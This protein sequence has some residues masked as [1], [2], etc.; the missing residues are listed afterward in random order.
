V[1]AFCIHASLPA[2]QRAIGPTLSSS[3][4]EFALSFPMGDKEVTRRCHVADRKIRVLDGSVLHCG[5]S[6]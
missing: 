5:L 3:R 1:S 4:A 6:N 2:V